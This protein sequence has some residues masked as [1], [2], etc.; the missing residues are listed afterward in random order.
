MSHRILQMKQA[1]KKPHCNCGAYIHAV[2][3]DP[4]GSVSV[5]QKQLFYPH[6]LTTERNSYFLVCSFP[7]YCCKSWQS[8]STWNECISL[9]CRHHLKYSVSFIF[10]IMLYYN[11]TAVSCFLSRN[12]WKPGI[13]LS[14]MCP[15]AVEIQMSVSLVWDCIK[16]VGQPA[17]PV[18]E[19]GDNSC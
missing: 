19:T 10:Y 17:M 8:N 7:P 15:Q 9:N 12:S 11:Y 6:F 18:L 2:G 1:N 14:L 3:R 16:P 13:A 4:A 5:V